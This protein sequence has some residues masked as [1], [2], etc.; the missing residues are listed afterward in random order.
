MNLKDYDTRTL[1]EVEQCQLA[2]FYLAY[3]RPYPPALTWRELRQEGF[4]P[5]EYTGCGI[6][7]IEEGMDEIDPLSTFHIDEDGNLTQGNSPRATWQ[8]RLINKWQRAYL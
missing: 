8:D 2:P 4:L 5:V 7:E 3:N 6:D 1:T